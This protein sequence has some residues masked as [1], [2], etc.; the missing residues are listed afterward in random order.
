MI[1][2]FVSGVAWGVVVAG[3]GLVVISQLAPLPPGLQHPAAPA[4]DLVPE[5]DADAADSPAELT[6][7]KATAAAPAPAQDQAGDKPAGETAGTGA[8]D[9][10]VQGTDAQGAA[11]QVPAGQDTESPEADAPADLLQPPQ[12]KTP[13]P[14]PPKVAPDAATPDPA[15]P[16]PAANPVAPSLPGQSAASSLPQVAPAAPAAGL[17]PSAP[18]EPPAPIVA[19]ARPFTNPGDRPLFAI[20]LVDDGAAELDRQ[21]LAALPF[22]VSFVLDP[23][24][25]QAAEAAKTY[26][27]GGH[28]VVMLASGLPPDPRP[29]DIEQSL[30]SDA[31]QLPEAVALVDLA[32]G[33]FQGN[34]GLASAIVP[35]LQDQ[36]RGLLT[37]DEGL[38]AADQVARR[39]GLP[40]ATIFRRLD[41]SGESLPTM[42]RYLDR[43]AFKAAQEGAVVVIGTAKAD[44]VSALVQWTIEGRATQVALAPVTAVLQAAK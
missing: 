22:P 38:N 35:I 5:T 44:T 8:Q 41:G 23:A 14:I 19:F 24:S 12:D 29:Q 10:E 32:E 37:Y 13:A 28:E 1:R 31:A 42:R 25:P 43:A 3:I 21:A 20:L 26:R 15:T 18:S 11:T 17:D 9:P 16:D 34:L 33:G 40:H 36:G 27:A 7:P 30:A 6:A 39:S 2:G 4:V